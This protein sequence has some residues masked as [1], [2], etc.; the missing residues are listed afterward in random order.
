MHSGIPLRCRAIARLKCNAGSSDLSAIAR[1]CAAMDS[2]TGRILP[3]DF[4]GCFATGRHPIWRRSIVE[5]V[6]RRCP[7]ARLAVRA[8]QPAERFRVVWIERQH[9]PIGRVGIGKTAGPQVIHRS[10]QRLRKFR[11]WHNIPTGLRCKLFPSALNRGLVP[12][13]TAAPGLDAS[14]AF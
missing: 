12:V 7:T 8:R 10:V 11:C 4:P 3:A 2:S 5:A 6:R 13:W 9:L 14:I 1:R